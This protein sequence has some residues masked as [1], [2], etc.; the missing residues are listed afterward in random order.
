LQ[1]P[2]GEA[3]GLDFIHQISAVGVEQ[4]TFN[5]VAM[6]NLDYQIEVIGPQRYC[7]TSTWTA[8]EPGDTPM[9]GFDV[10]NDFRGFG[11]LE[12]ACLGD[13]NGDGVVDGA[14]LGLLLGAWGDNPGSP[15]DLN[16]DGVVDGADLG[17]LLGAWGACG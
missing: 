3:P 5:Q 7:V 14:D 4:G 15:A 2:G 12:S 17:L 6:R 9:I 13:I 16:G 10:Q 8:I 11:R 1:G